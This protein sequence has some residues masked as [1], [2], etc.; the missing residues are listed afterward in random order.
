MNSLRS[1]I[2]T[3]RPT[4]RPSPRSG[5]CRGRPWELAAIKVE[6][7]LEGRKLTIDATV[8]GTGQDPMLECDVRTGAAAGPCE[9]YGSE[10]GASGGTKSY[11]FS[12]KMPPTAQNADITLILPR[13]RVVEFT[14][15]PVRLTSP[16][17][18]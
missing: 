3:S 15:R 11:K 10:I 5:R 4:V 17:G 16:A 6:P 2:A 8:T 14:A 9:P 18:Q 12:Y 13:I 7:L 1:S